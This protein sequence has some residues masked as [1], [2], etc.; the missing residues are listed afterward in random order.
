MLYMLGQRFIDNMGVPRCIIKVGFSRDLDKRINSYKSNNPT[1]IYISSTAGVEYEESR[2]HGYLALHG[3]H[4]SGEWYLVNNDFY[5]NCLK[6][7]FKGFP[8]KD[9]KQNIYM[10]IKYTDNE[11]ARYRIKMLYQNKEVV[12]S[13]KWNFN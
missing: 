7:G 2:C 3:T 4:Y 8:L 11:L 10:H 12:N 1:A 13:D 6:N 5:I 9:P